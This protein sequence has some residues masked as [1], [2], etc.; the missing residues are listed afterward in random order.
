MLARSSRV[1]TSALDPAAVSVVGGVRELLVRNQLLAWGRVEGWLISLL[2][3]ARWAGM[4]E[5]KWVDGICGGLNMVPYVDEV[6]T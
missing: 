3:F 5:L 4:L 6:E 1:S 2:Q